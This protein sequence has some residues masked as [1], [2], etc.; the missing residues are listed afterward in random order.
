MFK[1]RAG[2]GTYATRNNAI[3]A[4]QESGFEDLR[5][6]IAVNEQGRFFPV[7]FGEDAAVKGVHWRFPI[8]A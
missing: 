5:Y 7:F 8:I 3:K 1:D 4:V 2:S 6:V